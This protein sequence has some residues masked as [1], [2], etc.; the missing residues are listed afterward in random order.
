MV[1]YLTDH[2]GEMQETMENAIELFSLLIIII[3]YNQIIISLDLVLPLNTNMIEI[4]LDYAPIF[5]S[6]S[7]YVP[8]SFI[9]FFIRLFL[10]LFKVIHSIHAFPL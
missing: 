1:V 5:L 3:I 7:L 4:I 6:I 8:I 10:I 2:G 9:F